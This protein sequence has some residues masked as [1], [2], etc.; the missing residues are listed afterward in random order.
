MGVA[1]SAGLIVLGLLNFALTRWAGDYLAH[2]SL[3]FIPWGRDSL[4]L[5]RTMFT[6]ERRNEKRLPRTL[7]DEEL[8]RKDDIELYVARQ[9]AGGYIGAVFLTFLGILGLFGVFGP[10]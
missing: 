4:R 2:L 9:K 1:I 7:Y 3:K 8:L 6:Y 5:S 10:L